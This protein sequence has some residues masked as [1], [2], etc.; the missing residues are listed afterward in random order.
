M[1]VAAFMNNYVTMISLKYRLA[2][3][4]DTDLFNSPFTFPGLNVGYP[5]M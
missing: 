1:N 2:W 4:T 3:L 5:S